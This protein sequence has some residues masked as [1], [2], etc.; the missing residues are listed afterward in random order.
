[1]KSTNKLS[2]ALGTK[3]HFDNVLKRRWATAQQWR[4]TRRQS[5]QSPGKANWRVEVRQSLST[6]AQGWYT[7]FWHDWECWGERRSLSWQGMSGP[8]LQWLHFNSTSILILNS[9]RIVFQVNRNLD[10]LFFSTYCYY[11]TISSFESHVYTCLS[12][13]VFGKYLLYT[14]IHWHLLLKF[15]CALYFY[16]W[17]PSGAEGMGPMLGVSLWTKKSIL[18]M[19]D[20]Q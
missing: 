15:Q 11:F 14:I 8:A 12:H 16:F 18:Y 3:T 13:G 6:T 10:S 1:M 20:A 4:I 2:V 7:A 9:L 19:V 5:S 17:H